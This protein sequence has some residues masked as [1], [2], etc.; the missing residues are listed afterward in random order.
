M[1]LASLREIF[2]A[3]SPISLV[4]IKQVEITEEL[5]EIRCLCEALPEN[6]EIVARISF[7]S[8]SQGNGFFALPNAN[9]FGICV[10]SDDD[11]PIIVGFLS[12]SDDLIPEQVKDGDVVLKCLKKLHI[13]A[14]KINLGKADPSAEPD[15]PLPLGNVLLEYFTEIHTRLDAIIDAIVAGPVAIDSIGGQCPTNPA[16]IT[17]LN[18]EKTLLGTA[19][20]TYVDTDSSNVVSQIAF[21]ERGD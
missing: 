12:N 5:D 18:A 21:T 17:A 19:K 4:V 16:L 10:F 2:K 11:T 15:E 7:P 8:C 3:G 14:T 20:S 6:N 9:D 1:D 13:A